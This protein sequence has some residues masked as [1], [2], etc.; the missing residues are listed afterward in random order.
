MVQHMCLFQMSCF[1]SFLS[2]LLHSLSGK[3]CFNLKN[4]IKISSRTE[5]LRVSQEKICSTWNPKGR[6]KGPRQ[7]REKSGKR[8]VSLLEFPRKNTT[9]IVLI[10]H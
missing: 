5:H 3:P 2:G 6:R 7:R 1:P 8:T 4:K 9:F 10:T